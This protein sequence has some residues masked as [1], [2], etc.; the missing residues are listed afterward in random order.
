VSLAANLITLTATVTDGDGDKAHQ[1]L[2]LS[3]LLTIND[4]GPSVDFIESK[5]VENVAGTYDGAWSFASGA[6]GLSNIAI[7]LTNEAQI[8]LINHSTSSYDAATGIATYTAYFDAAGN[9]PYFTITMKSDGT[10]EFD[11]INAVPVTTITDNSSLLASIGGNNTSL[12]LEQIANKINHNDP[13][14]DPATDVLFTAHSGWTGGDHLGSTTTVNSNSNGLG[15][16]QGQPMDQNESLTLQFLIGDKDGSSSTH[17]TAVR[18]VDHIELDFAN[19][20]SGGQ[21]TGS[22]A[23]YVITYDQNGNVMTNATQNIVNGV[24]T[25]DAADSSHQIYSVTVVNSGNTGLVVTGMETEATVAT[26]NPPDVGLNF[27]VNVTD[28]DGDVTHQGFNIVIDANDGHQA[29]LIGTAGNDVLMGGPGNDILTGNGGNDIFVLQ[30]SGGGHDT[31]TDFSALDQIFVDISGQSFTS[32]TLTQAAIA[33]N[34]FMSGAGTG[35]GN[36]D[37]SNLFGSGNHFA[38]NTATQ[39]LYYS[40]DATA[41]HA[42]DLAHLSTGI[43]AAQIHTV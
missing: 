11:V 9:D 40:A 22:Y 7:S 6:D 31:I 20:S 36:S 42:I 17:P 14:K 29:T 23:V 39:E 38:F 10:Y 35:A 21:M 2:S 37:P 15:V 30:G 43:T 16:G 13:T 34:D 24:L 4:D 1:D 33:N 18:G 12:Y 3:N 25:L 19:G 26:Q 5:I 8:A 41:A 32:Q 28:G 27:N